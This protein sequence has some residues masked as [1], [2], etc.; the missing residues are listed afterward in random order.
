MLTPDVSST[1]PDVTACTRE[2]RTRARSRVLDQGFLVHPQLMGVMSTARARV[3]APGTSPQA[4]ESYD[5]PGERRDESAAG[6]EESERSR[7]RLRLVDGTPEE[8]DDPSFRESLIESFA[9]ADPASTEYL[10]RRFSGAVLRVAVSILGDRQLAE[11]AMQQTFV[12]AWKAASSYDPARALEPWLY[13]IARRTSIDLVRVEERAR[14]RSM[15]AQN[16]SSGVADDAVDRLC[17]QFEM[18]AALGRLRE[19]DRELLRMLYFEELSQADVASRLGVPLG[20]VKSR[21][22]RALAKLADVWSE[23]SLAS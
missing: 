21:S 13:Q 18:S 16:E 3:A 23:R 2:S 20:T 11:D 1:R 15:A 22:H 5:D 4:P 17:T 7:P 8:L 6:S 19:R 10:Y 9:K 14:R 12:K